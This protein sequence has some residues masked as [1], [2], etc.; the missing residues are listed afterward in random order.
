MKQIT[1]ATETVRRI[2]RRRSRMGE[3][4]SFVLTVDR[5]RCEGHGMCEQAAPELL[6]LNDDAEPVIDVDEIS[7][8][9]KSD[10]EAAVQSCPVAALRVSS[11]LPI[12]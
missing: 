12:S 2:V 8:A 3:H 11:R 9:R 1:G 4:Q 10:A 6:H 7:P 5:D